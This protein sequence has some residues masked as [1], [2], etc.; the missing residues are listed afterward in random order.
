MYTYKWLIVRCSYRRKLRNDALRNL[1]PKNINP[2]HTKRKNFNEQ[3][4]QFAEI[5]ITKQSTCSQCNPLSQSAIRPKKEP[6]KI[7]L[8]FLSYILF[9]CCVARLYIVSVL[10]SFLFSNIYIS[11]S[12]FSPCV[13]RLPI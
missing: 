9:A 3:Q 7:K 13:Y 2:Q 8:V 5:N 6:R 12:F 1:R 4:Q 10:C 11:Y